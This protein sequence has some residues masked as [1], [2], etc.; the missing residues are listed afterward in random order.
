MNQHSP[1]KAV[2]SKQEQLDFE[3]SNLTGKAK[4]AKLVNKASTKGLG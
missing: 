4:K 3:S 1:P 2:F